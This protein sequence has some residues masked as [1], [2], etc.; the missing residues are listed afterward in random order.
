MLVL[1]GSGLKNLNI[2]MWS[3]TISQVGRDYRRSLVQTLVQNRVKTEFRPGSSGHCQSSLENFQNYSLHKVSAGKMSSWLNFFF[4]TTSQISPFQFT[5]SVCHYPTMHHWEGLHLLDEIP[6]S[7][8]RMASR[9]L[10]SSLLSR[11]TSLSSL[12]RCCSLNYLGGPLLN[13][14]QFIDAVTYWG[15]DAKLNVVFHSKEE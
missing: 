12:S 3:Y 1:G 8:G 9:F 5:T 10:C 4:L 2:C 14:L 6:I 7:A 13:L 11:L 15:V